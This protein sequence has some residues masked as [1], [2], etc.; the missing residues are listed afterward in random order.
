MYSFVSEGEELHNFSYWLK[1]FP[2]ANPEAVNIKRNEILTHL[3]ST[4]DLVSKEGI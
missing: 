4:F 3:Q 1:E 2:E